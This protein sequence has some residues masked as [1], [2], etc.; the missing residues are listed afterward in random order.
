MKTPTTRNPV[1]LSAMARC[2]Q[3]GFHFKLDPRH[4]WLRGRLSNPDGVLWIRDNVPELARFAIRCDA[5]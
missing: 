1:L 2:L 4:V 3:H 5:P